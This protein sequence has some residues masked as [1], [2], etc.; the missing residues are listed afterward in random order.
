LDLRR[1]TLLRELRDRGTLAAVA[2]AL[3]FSPSAVSQQLAQLQAEVGV[4]LVERR[5]RILELTQ[6]GR[7]L[8][9]D[10]EA[11]FEQVERART[12][13]EAFKSGVGGTIRV[14]AFQTAA[15]VVLPL[16]L[17]SL[18]GDT[19]LRVEVFEL[20]PEDSLP[21]LAR[22]GVDLVVG[23][24]YEQAPR[25]LHPGISRRVEH[26]EPVLVALPPADPLASRRRPLQLAAL[27]DRTW[28]SGQQGTGYAEALLRAARNAGFE[29]DIRYRSNDVTVFL[30]LV[31]HGHAVALVP[32]LALASP[33]RPAVSLH[34]ARDARL[35]RHIFTAVRR[36]DEGRPALARVR[37]AVAAGIGQAAGAAATT[38]R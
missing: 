21:L 13:V 4:Q 2:Q 11:I 31:A 16:A 30:S 10:S 38:A 26:D 5:G 36:G 8:A 32:S 3:N 28:A 37:E 9:E 6:A 34:T 35:A 27:A 1:L 12:H 17:T 25:S 22:G 33:T 20:E 19:N 7:S 23:Q 18:A 15:S 24:E 29:P 14:A